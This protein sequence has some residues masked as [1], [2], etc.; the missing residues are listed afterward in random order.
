MRLWTLAW[1]NPPCWGTRQSKNPFP[2]NMFL[3]FVLLTL[4]EIPFPKMQDTLSCHWQLLDSPML[5]WL[6]TLCPEKTTQWSQLIIQAPEWGGPAQAV[7]NSLY[8]M[9]AVMS[10]SD[11]TMTLQ[12][13]LLKTEDDHWWPTRV[14]DWWVVK[15][16]D[17][18][19]SKQLSSDWTSRLSK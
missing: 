7:W 4:C 16:L 8:Q 14:M 15:T 2:V 18:D 19:L 12:S 6:P 10:H 9:F 1:D 5:P 11:P 13:L 17:Y 3:T